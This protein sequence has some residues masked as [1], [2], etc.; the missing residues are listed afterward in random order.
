MLDLEVE[1]LQAFLPSGLLPNDV[2]RT[3]QPGRSSVI[4]P[5][6]EFTS[7]QVLLELLEKVN[8]SQKFLTHG[9][10]VYFRLA[11]RP[12][13]VGD[14]AFL[15]SLDLRQHGSNGVVTRSGVQYV[16]VLISQHCQHRRRRKS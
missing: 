8:H 6:D 2:W 13:G 12:T 11:V 1:L 14:H 10:V 15:P 3:L 7:E 9:A 5:D 16:R 4:R